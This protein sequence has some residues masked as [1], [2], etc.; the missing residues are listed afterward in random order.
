MRCA[1]TRF[2]GSACGHRYHRLQ[3]RERRVDPRVEIVDDERT[4]A[5]V[6]LDDFA[7]PSDDDHLPPD[8]DHRGAE[9]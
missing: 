7:R 3:E 4:A 9:P 1:T 2:G 5:R 8:Y 6:E